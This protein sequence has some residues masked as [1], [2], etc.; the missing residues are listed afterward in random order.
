LV[1]DYLPRNSPQSGGLFFAE[2]P[3]AAGMEIEL[4]ASGYV[5]P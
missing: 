2:D 1:F 4:R 5:E 3:R